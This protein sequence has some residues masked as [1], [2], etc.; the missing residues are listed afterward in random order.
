M[1]SSWPQRLG[2]FSEN[3]EPGILRTLFSEDVRITEGREAFC[4]GAKEQ[5]IAAH[6][7]AFMSPFRWLILPPKRFSEHQ[8]PVSMNNWRQLILNSPTALSSQDSSSES[9]SHH[10]L[11]V[12]GK[13]YPPRTWLRLRHPN[14]TACG[15]DPEVKE[16][17]T[18]SPWAPTAH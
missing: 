3:W 18:G 15:S 10:S 9:F 7:A 6:H 4:P 14:H 12:L 16:L 5:Q 8:V 1:G 2:C 13:C 11:H 17:W